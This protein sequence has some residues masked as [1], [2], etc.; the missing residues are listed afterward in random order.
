M[1]PNETPTKQYG[2]YIASKTIH[3]D[4]WRKLRSVGW[5]II[6]TWIDEAGIG[7]TSDFTDL[8]RRCIAEASNAAV[9]FLYREPGEQLKGAFVECGA[10]LASGVPVIAT[11]CGAFSLVSHPLVTQV[12]GI[13]A[14]LIVVEQMGYLGRQSCAVSI[15]A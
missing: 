4:K 10:A 12:E 2:I 15:S 5:P 8:W 6:S 14:A 7:E 9:L 3:A 11:G 1:K 13:P